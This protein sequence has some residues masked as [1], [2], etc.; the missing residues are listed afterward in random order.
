M[1]CSLIASFSQHRWPELVMG[2]C[3]IALLLGIKY[4]AVH[5]R[6][7]LD[8]NLHTMTCPSCTSPGSDVTPL[9]C[10]VHHALILPCLNKPY[11]AVS[12]VRPEDCRHP[13]LVH[14]TT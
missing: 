1:L 14:V 2:L 7:V 9:L 4:I 8:P 5:H 10:V 3:C 11:L 12:Q 6:Y 13:S